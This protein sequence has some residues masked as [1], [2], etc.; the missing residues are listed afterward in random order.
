[1][2]SPNT[3]LA[4]LDKLCW[5]VGTVEGPEFGSLKI[6]AKIRD[7]TDKIT[8]MRNTEQ[9]EQRNTGWQ[10]HLPQLQQMEKALQ[11][12]NEMFSP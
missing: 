10:N 1:M 5:V 11:V 7:L 3:N 4:H 2:G 12:F 9:L 8:E 6:Q